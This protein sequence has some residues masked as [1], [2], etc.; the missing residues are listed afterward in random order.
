VPAT[1][2][3][4][5]TYG[6]LCRWDRGLNRCTAE[7]G[8]IL[9]NLFS[10]R[11]YDVRSLLPDHWQESLLNVA[12]SRSRSKDLIPISVTSRESPD[13]ERVHVTTVG[14]LSLSEEA[15]WLAA[16]YQYEFR[17][18][19]QEAFCTEVV[20]AVDQRIGINLNVQRGR[21]Q[22]Y[23]AH[24]DSN[25]I[26]GL[27]YVT[28]NPPGTG[29]ELVVANQSDALGT[30]AIDSD[31]SVV[32]PIAG[33]LIFFDARNSPHYVRPLSSDSD[34]RV[35]VAMNFYTSYSREIDRPADLNFHLFGEQ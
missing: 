16:L 29:G 11:G 3:L 26:E 24:V 22:R 30:A 18:L 7:G 4:A 5:L 17:A 8:R 19:A 35:V 33:H 9:K 23:E 25:P 21:T 1:C 15:P 34:L 20:C 12:Q 28:T 10:W 6:L 14:G 32:Y 27:L 31:C 2:F 13:V